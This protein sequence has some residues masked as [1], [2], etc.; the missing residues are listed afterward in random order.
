M[1]GHIKCMTRFFLDQ[2]RI[3]KP[4]ENGIDY[5]FPIAERYTPLHTNFLS[6]HWPSSNR[7]KTLKIAKLV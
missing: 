1:K 3:I 6:H 4:L 5:E 2:C 7:R